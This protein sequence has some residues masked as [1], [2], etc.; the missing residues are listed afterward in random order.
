MGG[1]SEILQ[2]RV[3]LITGKGGVGRSTVAAALAVACARA[4]RRVLLTEIGEGVRP[5][6]LEPDDAQAKGLASADYSPL[7]RIFGLDRFPEER[8]E[9]APNVWGGLLM[10]LK[11]QE[12][13][14]K[15]VFKLGPIV[16]A[17]LA[18]EALRRLFQAAPSV[19]EMGIFFHLL[20]Y[21]RETRLL[22]GPQFEMI[23]VD[24]PATGHALALAGLPNI[25][26]HMLPRGPIAEA[27]REGQAVLSDPK[28]TAA[29]VVTL[30]EELPLG[31]TLEL[32]EALKKT[33]TPAGGVVL[34]HVPEDP[35]SPGE[36]QALEESLA[37]TNVLGFDGF[38]YF[39][40]CKRA[41]A[42]LEQS[43]SL[44]L[45]RLPEAPVVGLAPVRD[46]LADE[47]ARHFKESGQ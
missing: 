19:R 37:T 20:G 39:L 6:D 21:L 18:S 33:G 43:V 16:K 24:M 29:W 14:L 45:L 35:F 28:Q 4:G 12:L 30:P 7:A 22:S 44:P 17:A 2:K 38:Q 1:I 5:E 15:S 31:E 3:V 47:I 9:V 41:I 34:N 10:P 42:K 46:F 23:V 13:F 11:G 25:L 26:L 40:G 8:A 32:L 27:L 36:R